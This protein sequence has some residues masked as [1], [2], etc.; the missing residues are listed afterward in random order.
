M[1]MRDVGAKAHLLG[2]EMALLISKPGSLLDMASL[3]GL[4]RVVKQSMACSVFFQGKLV[5][6]QLLAGWDC[7]HKPK[8][9]LSMKHLWHPVHPL[10]PV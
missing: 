2:L 10:P 7:A 4:N 8:F 3:A 9:D 5:H 1:L 6:T